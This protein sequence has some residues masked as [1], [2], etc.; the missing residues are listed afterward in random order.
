[1]LD[2]GVYT[3]DPSEYH[4]D[5]VEGGSLSSTGARML[6][7]TSPATFRWWTDN[8]GERATKAVWDFGTS[9]HT[10]LLGI[11]PDIDVLD[12]QDWRKND[13]KTAAAES[14]QAGR[15]PLLA[16]EYD[17]IPRMVEQL[18]AHPLAGHLFRPGRGTAE[19]VLVWRCPETGVMCRAMLDW[20]PKSR[21]LLVD[22]KTTASAHPEAISRSVYNYQYHV[23]AAHYLD[24]AQV[25]G[26]VDEHCPFSFVFQEKT[27]P[28]LVNVVYLNALS[29]RIG[30][31]RLLRARRL[32][33]GCV[34]AGHWPG[35][36]EEIMS[37]IGLPAFAEREYMED[38]YDA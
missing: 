3:M 38:G 8:P 18:K 32:Y 33:A 23:Q 6:L 7:D 25:L 5:P 15:I 35:Y 11:G 37:E 30:R 26:L 31:D 14:R 29:M 36:S 1:M 21:S 24:G 27:P 20:L 2:V 10:R 19:T 34:E 17:H 13:A 9:A 22:Y 16:K 4:T 12:F 28:Y